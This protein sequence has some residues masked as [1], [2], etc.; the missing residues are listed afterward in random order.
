[1]INIFD[2]RRLVAKVS[3]DQI[4]GNKTVVTTKMNPSGNIDI[5]IESDCEKVKSLAGK[6]KE[7]SIKDSYMPFE[8]NPIFILA[9]KNNVTLTCLVPAAIVNAIWEE[10]GLIAKSLALNAKELKIIFEE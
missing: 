4:C 9:G 3:V 10:A 1:Y 7:I 2:N 5:L 6:L 8:E